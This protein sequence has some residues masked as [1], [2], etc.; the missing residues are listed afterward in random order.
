MLDKEFD[1]FRLLNELRLKDV[2]GGEN[3]VAYAYGLCFGQLTEKQ[4]AIIARIVNKM[5]NK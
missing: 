4:K 3:P 1:T 2:V 5:E